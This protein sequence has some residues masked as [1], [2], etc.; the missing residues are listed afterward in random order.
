MEIR[1]I[2]KSTIPSAS[3]IS[4][5]AIN[6]IEFLLP[7]SETENFTTL[8]TQLENQPNTSVF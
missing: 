3:E 8:F 7:F 4:Q 2:I 5:T 1:T 6:N